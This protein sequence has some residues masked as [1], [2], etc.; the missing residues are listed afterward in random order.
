MTGH[1]GTTEPNRKQA[2]WRCKVELSICNLGM[3]GMNTKVERDTHLC[4][5]KN[6]DEGR[7]ERGK[8]MG[9]WMGSW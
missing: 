4:E 8:R 1:S 6:E 5:R 9:E 3:S 2:R 7:E